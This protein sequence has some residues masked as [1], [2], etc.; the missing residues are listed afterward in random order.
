MNELIRQLNPDKNCIGGERC[1]APIAP[2]LFQDFTVLGEGE[3]DVAITV[4]EVPPGEPA[5][6]GGQILVN[7]CYNLEVTIDFI[8]GG[9]CDCCTQD[10]LAVET[11]TLIVPANS[12]FPLP[13]AYWQG[14][15]YRLIDDAGNPVSLPAGEFQTINAYSTYTPACPECIVDAIAPTV[16]TICS[17]NSPTATCIVWKDFG[18][19]TSLDVNT[20]LGTL[21]DVELNISLGSG[22]CPGFSGSFVSIDNGSG[23]EDVLPNDNTN[24]ESWINANLGGVGFAAIPAS[25]PY[26]GGGGSDLYRYMELTYP[27]AEPWSIT[28]Q[29]L[30]ESYGNNAYSGVLYDF[31]GVNLTVSLI[32]SGGNIVTGPGGNYSDVGQPLQVGC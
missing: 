6:F 1:V 27:T 5:Y 13:S 23:V 11:A 2:I 29:N 10:D 7:G 14:L 19:T 22:D 24:L 20:S 28:I 8:T 3:G 12:A 17:G 21:Q 32:D 9:D 31:D 16:Q 30:P 15:S 25:Q 4:V 26:V 18:S